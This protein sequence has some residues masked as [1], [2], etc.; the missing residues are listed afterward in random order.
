MSLFQCLSS[1]ATFPKGSF[2][3]RLDTE[4]PP[5]FVGRSIFS[6][7]GSSSLSFIFPRLRSVFLHRLNYLFPCPST[8]RHG[9][10]SPVGVSTVA[11]YAFRTSLS[12]FVHYVPIYGQ[13]IQRLVE[14]SFGRPSCH[15][16]RLQSGT[17]GLYTYPQLATVV[18]YTENTGLDVAV[19]GKDNTHP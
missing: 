17:I 1:P 10:S 3:R 2:R 4:V 9:S 5:R 8:S 16:P 19:W 12:S 13:P 15:P 7:A 6:S 18:Q 11:H 14:P